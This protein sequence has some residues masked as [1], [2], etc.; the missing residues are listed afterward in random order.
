M[1][2]GRAIGQQAA[3]GVWFTE[4]M[5]CA[6]TC[7]VCGSVF[8]GGGGGGGGTI[9]TASSVSDTAS[10]SS[11]FSRL[12]GGIFCQGSFEKQKKYTFHES[13]PHS[14]AC[15]RRRQLMREGRRSF[16]RRR[17][18]GSRPKSRTAR[19]S[20]KSSHLVKKKR[21]VMEE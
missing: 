11:G 6:H 18:I 19:A 15:V 9:C 16:I 5:S 1:A 17:S 7:P 3:V 14:A 13:L 2:G 4:R 21:M 8:A 20:N 12:Y 10:F